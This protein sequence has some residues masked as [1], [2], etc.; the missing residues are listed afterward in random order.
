MEST[1]SHTSRAPLAP[2][3]IL[4]GVAYDATC[5][6][7]ATYGLTLARHFAVPTH[8][9]HA[10]ESP[11]AGHA[12]TSDSIPPRSDAPPSRSKESDLLE[13][14]RQSEVEAMEAFVASL[15]A[16]QPITW[17]VESGDSKSVLL[18]C[19]QR[20]PGS[21]V[22]LGARRHAALAQWFLG[23]TAGYV[24]RHCQVPVLVVPPQPAS[25]KP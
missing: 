1:P 23:S 16:N 25:S 10:S 15:N 11:Y 18:E 6:A 21:W 3:A 7:A 19:A 4:V 5:H 2:D 13:A 22:V 14:L 8:L 12:L 24:V 20:S 9:V 17:R